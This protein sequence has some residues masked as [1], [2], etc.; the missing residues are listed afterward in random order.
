MKEE[1]QKSVVI[2][3]K[4]IK[5]GLR[6]VI[7]LFGIYL[8]LFAIRFVQLNFTG[9]QTWTADNIPRHLVPNLDAEQC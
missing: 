8:A 3:K 2:N 5:I 9:K 4:W 6:C 1:Q 7:A